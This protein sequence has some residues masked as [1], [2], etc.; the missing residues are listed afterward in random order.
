MNEFIQHMMV[1]GVLGGILIAG[2]CVGVVWGLWVI[3]LFD[4]KDP[5]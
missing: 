1:F 4:M 2:V 3:G 5:R